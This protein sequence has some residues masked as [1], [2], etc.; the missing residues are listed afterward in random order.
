MPFEKGVSGNEEAKFKPGQ[1][2]NPNGRPKLPDLTEMIFDEVGEEGLRA[3]ILKLGQLAKNGNIK[4]IQ[5]LL[6]RGYGK[7]KQSVAYEGEL[8][9][10]STK[11][12]T[13]EELAAIAANQPTGSR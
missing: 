13:D 2:G 4:A 5:E 10:K 12:L 8:K 3:A 11:D 9:I 6:D 1:S 7:S